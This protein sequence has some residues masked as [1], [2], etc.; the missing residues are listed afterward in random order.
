M[1]GRWTEKS[2]HRRLSNPPK[3]SMSTRFAVI[4]ST[5]CLVL[6]AG[7]R[8]A[9]ADEVEAFTDYARVT[10]VTPI[11]ES[12][13]TPIPNER[14]WDHSRADGGEAEHLA[15]H[16][17]PLPYDDDRRV[18]SSIGN[19]IRNEQRRRRMAQWQQCNRL[20]EQPGQRRVV[21]YNVRYRYGGETFLRRMKQEPGR[22]VRVRVELQ[23]VY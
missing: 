10:E 14:C 13:D 11:L 23:P 4:V 19:D 22:R 8:P 15:D 18:A 9:L 21:G 7:C 1:S 2:G 16:D 17:S 5:L 12:V 20:R 3:P 6:A